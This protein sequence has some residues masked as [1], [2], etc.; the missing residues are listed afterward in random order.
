MHPN[1]SVHLRASVTRPGK[2]DDFD[3]VTPPNK[4]MRE[5]AHVEI[6][7]TDKGWGVTVSGLK[8]AHQTVS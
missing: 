4:F 3:F 5:H 1:C 2:R 8:D 7:P 6:A